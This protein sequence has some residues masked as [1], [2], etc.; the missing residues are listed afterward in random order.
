MELTQRERFRIARAR[1]EALYYYSLFCSKANEVPREDLL[2]LIKNATD[3]N[4]L[5]QI[6]EINKGAIEKLK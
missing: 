3:F 6:E 1:E 5:E 2:V 4:A